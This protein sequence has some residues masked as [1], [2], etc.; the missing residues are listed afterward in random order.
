MK[1][2]QINS[3]CGVGS[4]GRIAVDISKKLND[5]NIK[6]YILY[7][8]G[9]SVYPNGIKIGGTANI[10]SHQLKTRLLGKH[11]FY[12]ELAT[13][14]MVNKLE[15]IKPDIV[16]LHNLHGHFLNV[17]LLF[18]YLSKANVEVIWTLHDCWS[19]TGHCA[20]FDHIGCEKWKTGCGS[21]PQLH[22]YPN[23]LIFDRS[24]EAFIDKRRLFTSVKNMTIVTP[25]KWLSGKVKQSFLN[26]FPI[27]NIN[28]GI[29]LNIFK[30]RES[31]LR[32]KYNLTNK[33]VILGVAG[34][35]DEKKG[36]N[37]FIDLSERI[38]RDE[39]IILV[40]LTKK[41]K[42]S[43]PR[44]ITGITR[45]QNINELAEFYS[46][47]DVFVNPTLE[48][49]FPTTNIEA[50]ACGTPVITYRTGGSPEIIDKKTGIVVERGNISELERAIKKVKKNGKG[51]YSQECIK[52]AKNNFDKYNRY[53][54]YITLYRS[55]IKQP[56]TNNFVN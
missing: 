46:V 43:L 24:N 56:N 39:A 36:I 41:Q 51:V 27:M 12:S 6:N 20:H 16:H 17:E 19:F 48:D 21:C 1:V 52:R 2:V 25:S 42:G 45:T 22:S 54:D 53:E 26:G 34:N 30:P 10:R 18:N 47:A 11:G 32:E 23:S 4:T 7:G 38:N 14:Q 33:F 5:S 3:V 28:N 40:G 35:W 8:V 37:D 50:L 13:I 44:N 49:T 55:K 9:N 29:D 31:N 15:E